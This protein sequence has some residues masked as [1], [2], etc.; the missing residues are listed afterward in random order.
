MVINKVYNI[1]QVRQYLPD[2]E[3]DASKRIP[4][5]F[6]FAIVHKLDPEFFRRAIDEIE[7]TQ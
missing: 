1:P 5:Q 6:L 2:F 4:R 3:K 7:R